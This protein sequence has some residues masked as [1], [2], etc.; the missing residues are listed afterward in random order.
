MVGSGD[1]PGSEEGVT[2]TP[3]SGGYIELRKVEGKRG[4]RRKYGL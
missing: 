1:R 2:Q 4:E 3:F